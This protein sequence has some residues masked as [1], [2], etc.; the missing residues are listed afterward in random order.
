MICDLCNRI[1]SS[2]IPLQVCFCSLQPDKILL[3]QQVPQRPT[4][5]QDH[6]SLQYFAMYSLDTQNLML[7]VADI[8]FCYYADLKIIFC[9]KT[10]IIIISGVGFTHENSELIHY[11]FYHFKLGVDIKTTNF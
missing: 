2:R 6:L 10:M 5:Y 4:R 1:L 9:F 7:Y 3:T 8:I 11:K